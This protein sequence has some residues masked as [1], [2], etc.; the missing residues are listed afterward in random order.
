[1]TL[2]TNGQFQISNVVI[3]ALGD[4][5][6]AEERAAPATPWGLHEAVKDF[7]DNPKEPGAALKVRKI[8][9]DSHSEADFPK[10]LAAF[11][12]DPGATASVNT[13]YNQLWGTGGVPPPVSVA[14]PTA[15]IRRLARMK[16]EGACFDTTM[17][18]AKK[19]Q[20]A[21]NEPIDFVGTPFSG[22]Q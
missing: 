22:G 11:S 5:Y 19:F 1:P 8:I 14:A 7:L 13:Q 21:R 17:S 4:I 2:V 3:K 20:V 16:E 18:M 6:L 10:T 15:D 9:T 12:N